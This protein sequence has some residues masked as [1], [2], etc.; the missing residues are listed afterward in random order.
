MKPDEPVTSEERDT[1]P[2][3][4]RPRVGL[5]LTALLAVTVLTAWLNY[6]CFHADEYFQTI[7][8]ARYKLAP[9]EVPELPWEVAS[10][11]RPWLQPLLYFV[12]GRGLAVFGVRDIEDLGFVFRL[13]MGVISVFTLRSFLKTT[14]PWERSAAAAKLNLYV[15]TMTGFLPYLFVRT[16]SEA[17]SM[18]ALTGGFTVLLHASRPI[19]PRQWEVPALDAL[20]R[21]ALSGFL[22]GVAFELRFQTAF[23]TMGLIA[24]MLL[25]TSA[26]RQRRLRALAAMTAGGGGALVVGALVDRWGYGQWTFTPWRYFVV[27]VVDGVAKKY[28]QDAPFA[29]FWLLPANVFMPVVLLLLALAVLAWLR[30]PRHPITW[31]TLPFFVVHNLISHKEE[32]FLFPIA[33]LATAFATM[34]LAPTPDRDPSDLVERI[35]AWGWERRARGPVKALVV[36]SF[37]VMALLAVYPL[38]WQRHARFIRVLRANVGEEFHGMALPDVEPHYPE[39][40][41]AIFDLEIVDDA[42]LARR[43]E[44]G[45]AREWLIADDATRGSGS[46]YVDAHITLVYS[47]L[48]GY[49]SPWWRERMLE[50]TGYYNAHQRAPLRPIT[51]RSLYRVTAP[52]R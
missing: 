45:T 7:E 28:G 50:I 20:K 35:A 27:N 3:V 34:A 40:H 43:I 52:R 46:A 10:R 48:P 16:S 30:W 47:E 42:E 8:L 49:R 21:V 2:P 9:G 5:Y 44:A 39:Y 12:I 11:I 38:N 4:N 29:Y 15:A 37:M 14:L 13:L 1:P 31:A 41:P 32:R 33:I 24:W 26:D 51:F 22:F 25:Y 18:A 36:A 19:G 17:T 6:A 23:V